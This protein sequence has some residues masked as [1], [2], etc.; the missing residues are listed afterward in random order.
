[1][2]QIRLWEITSDQKLAEIPVDPI[3]L[4]ERLEDWLASDIDV[5]DAN[6]LV[7]GRQVETDFR[8]KIDLLCLD[9]LGNTVVIELKKER[10]PRDV[11]AQALEYAS[12]VKNLTSERLIE[13]AD[14]Y[15]ESSDALE[16]KFLEKFREE[17]PSELN[18]DHRSLIV[19][20]ETDQ[21]TRRIVRYLSEMSVRINV[22]TVRHFKGADGREML[23]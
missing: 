4:E 19:A 1:M 23:A 15:F 14:R 20:E 13:I 12:W 3:S 22:A 17:L 21:S 8:G 11:T 7:I 2:Q 5:L 6:L 18:Q 10:T 9:G 16:V